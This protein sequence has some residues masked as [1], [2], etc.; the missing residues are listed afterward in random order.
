MIREVVLVRHAKPTLDA[1]IPRS[2]WRL[3]DEGA[4]EAA[5]LGERLGS[6][7][8]KFRVSSSDEVKAVETA[9]EVARALGD[10]RRPS[11]DARFGEISH[12]WIELGRAEKVLAYLDGE[13]HEGWEPANVATARFAGALEALGRT[14]TPLVVTHGIVMSLFV[15]TISADIDAAAFWREL[16]MPDAWLLDLESGRRERL[17]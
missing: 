1:A 14:A 8:M 4:G 9:S 3:T 16:T 10:R 2:Q 7:G 17:G 6:R 5:R 13:D 12:P 11:V 15:A